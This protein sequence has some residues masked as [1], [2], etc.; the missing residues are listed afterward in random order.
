MAA[1]DLKPTRME[2]AKEAA[3]AFVDRQPATVQV[4]VVS[5]SDSGFAVQPPTNEQA[6][7]LA[8]IDRLR[9]ERG[10]SLAH[11]ILTALNAIFA[12]RRVAVRNGGDGVAVAGQLLYSDLTPSPTPSPT[13]VPAGTLRPP[14]SCC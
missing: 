1:D 3:R 2:A 7:I 8:A 13:P 11:G 5:F 10:T 6:T 4:G 14:P 12:R 9:P